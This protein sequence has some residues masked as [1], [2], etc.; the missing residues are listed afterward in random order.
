MRTVGDRVG[1][2]VQWLL[3]SGVQ[4]P[5]GGFA[6]WYD[7][8]RG[9]H[10]YVYAEITG[11]ATTVLCWWHART[12]D[13]QCLVAAV[14]AGDW[15]VRSQDAAGGFRC[16]VP[17]RA[18]RFDVKQD[19]MFA[20]DTGVIVNGLTNL[21]RATGDGRYLA[22]AVRAADWLTDAAQLPGGGFRPVFDTRRGEFAPTDD[23]WSSQPGGYHT[24]VAAGLANLAEVTGTRRYRQAAVRACAYALDHQDPDGRVVGSD[25]GTHAHPHAYTAEGLWA[26][27]T[28]L[29]LPTYVEASRRATAWLLGLQ[30]DDATVPRFV[31]DGV[32]VYA[33]R[34]DV[35]AQALRLARIHRLEEP[36]GSLTDVLLDAQ[37]GTHDRDRSQ[38]D[39]DARERGDAPGA[40][41]ADPHHGDPRVTGGW[42]FGQL[43]DGQRVPHVNM[44]T[45]AFAVQA[46]DLCDGAPLDPR[47]LV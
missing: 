28:L 46:L 40:D 39:G 23:G 30:R 29:E 19:L 14:A 21:Y 33:H 1:A 22:A 32:P 44:W 8:E 9:D 3:R 5:D 7:A 41:G 20:F 25:G 26:T 42:W 10:P 12:G 31:R 24:K 17:L 18:T 2:G 15:L 4:R 34:M 35:Q 13:D 11:Y 27:G 16:L 36:A 37:A 43:A 6:A 45:T 38:D 47:L